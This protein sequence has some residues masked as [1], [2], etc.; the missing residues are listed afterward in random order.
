MAEHGGSSTTLLLVAGAGIGAYFYWPEL[1]AWLNSLG[2]PVTPSAAATITP[3]QSIAN[4]PNLPPATPAGVQTTNS[5]PSINTPGAVP[6]GTQGCFSYQGTISCPPGVSPPPP[7]QPQPVCQ[8]GWTPDANGVC[9]QYSDQQ[10]I[11]GFNSIPWSGLTSIP[12]EQINRIDPQILASYTQVNG[13]TPGSVLAYMLGLGGGA[14]ANTQATGSDGNLYEMQAGLWVRVVSGQTTALAGFGRLG[15]IGLSR[16]RAALPVTNATLAKASYDPETAAILGSDPRGL[17]TVPQW[18]YFY[19]QAS[20]VLQTQ[21]THPFGE[22]GAKINASQYQALR[23]QAGLPV[24]LG[25]IRKSYPGAFP[26][27][28][29]APGPSRQP[30]VYVGNR[31]IY[32]IPGRGAVPQKMGTI[33][34]GGGDHRWARSPF[35]RPATWRQAEP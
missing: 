11:D 19:S 22:Q 24:S 27:G 18:N 29:I 35:P 34:T 33:Q 31:N 21:P 4:P 6:V 26:L 17:L 20:G 14:A 32:R 25:T 30:F 16:L 10:L 8:P 23:V 28:S 12:A 3:A 15:R 9:T 1:S 7:A 2:L 13:V 5:S